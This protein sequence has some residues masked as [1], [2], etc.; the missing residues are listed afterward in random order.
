M[1]GEFWPPESLTQLLLAFLT[2]SFLLQAVSRST[3]QLAV[4]MRHQC[5]DATIVGD[6]VVLAPFTNIR[7]IIAST[8][9]LIITVVEAHVRIEKIL[10]FRPVVSK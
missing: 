8:S 9:L 6:R 1:G 4:E 2:V 5:S 3:F 7:I 10:A